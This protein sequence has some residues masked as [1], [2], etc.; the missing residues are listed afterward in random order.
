MSEFETIQNYY[1]KLVINYV[2]T[3]IQ[4]DNS[5]VNYLADVVCVALNHLPP[6]YI[7]YEVDMAFYLSPVERQEMD[8]KIKS[9]VEDAVLFIKKSTQKIQKKKA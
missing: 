8:A 3:N 4:P 6:R 5:D 9:A 2:K 7:R 1:K